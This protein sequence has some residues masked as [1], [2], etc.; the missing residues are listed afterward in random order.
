MTGS[1][2]NRIIA[3]GLNAPGPLLLVKKRLDEFRGGHLRIIVSRDDAAD[4]LVDYFIEMGAKVEIDHA[5]DDI[6]VVVDL[7]ESGEDE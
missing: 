2:E 6:H 1:D 4:E 3:R 7:T 5:G